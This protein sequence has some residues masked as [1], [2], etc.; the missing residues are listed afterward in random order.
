MT[1]A[2]SYCE[3]PSKKPRDRPWDAQVSGL[4]VAAGGMRFDG[5]PDLSSGPSKRT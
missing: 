2:G 1:T 3:R 4:Q 5:L